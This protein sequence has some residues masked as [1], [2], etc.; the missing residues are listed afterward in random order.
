MVD[1]RKRVQEQGQAI[2]EI[3]VPEWS[4]PGEV[5]IV[6]AKPLKTR[7]ATALRELA[8]G[9]IERLYVFAV[10]YHALKKNGDRLFADND[11]DL[12]IE[13]ADA[14]VV[15]RI[16]QAI[17]HS[18]TQDQIVADFMKTLTGSANSQSPTNAD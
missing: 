15:T 4:E 6:Y 14:D 12:L 8:D 3:P 5:L 16:G 7:Q 2:R 18:K 10:L 11:M 1:I 13:Q 9:A 17:V